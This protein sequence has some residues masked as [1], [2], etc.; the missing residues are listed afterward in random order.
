MGKEKVRRFRVEKNLNQFSGG[1]L[2][3]GGIPIEL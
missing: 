1:F 3:K 2:S